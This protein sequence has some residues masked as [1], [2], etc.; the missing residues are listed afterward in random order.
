MGFFSD[1][2]ED[3]SQVM[4]GLLPENAGPPPEDE[5]A[6]EAMAL[7]IPDASDRES[8]G[9]AISG[10]SDEEPV[11]DPMNFDG[12]KVSLEEML[13]NLDVNM[14]LPEETEEAEPADG[15]ESSY[16]AVWSKQVDRVEEIDKPIQE[17]AEEETEQ[18]VWAQEIL[19]ESESPEMAALLQRMIEDNFPEG[20]QV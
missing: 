20:P 11:E 5:Q 9:E 3:L 15:T 6:E 2:K 7:E 8:P 12:L 16:E 18:P 4:N 17:T 19:G 14:Q 10:Q 1:L 13:A